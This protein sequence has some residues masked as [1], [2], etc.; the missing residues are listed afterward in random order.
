MEETS[1]KSWALIIVWRG[2]FSFSGTAWVALE[3]TG[4]EVQE[5]VIVDRSRLPLKHDGGRVLVTTEEEW[6][7]EYAFVASRP[8][9]LRITGRS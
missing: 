1:S 5:E 8:A 7:S 4:S 9:Y 2:G 3:G 6:T